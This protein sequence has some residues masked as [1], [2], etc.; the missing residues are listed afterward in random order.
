MT[1]ASGGDQYS[2]KYTTKRME[3]ALRRA[4]NTPHKPPA[5]EK[6]PCVK[7]AKPSRANVRK[8]AAKGGR[9]LSAAAF[10]PE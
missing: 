8:A 2:E 9:F 7:K 3:D 4:L 6:H 5:E 1:R 10:A